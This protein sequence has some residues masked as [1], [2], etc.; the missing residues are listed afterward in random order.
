MK[1]ALALA[2]TL[3]FSYTSWAQTQLNQ[4]SV[5]SNL[6]P[7]SGANLKLLGRGI[8]TKDKKQK[9]LIACV[10]PTTTVEPTCETLRFVYVNEQHEGF[11]AGKAFPL[12][13]GKHMRARVKDTLKQLKND[14][15]HFRQHEQLMAIPFVASAGAVFGAVKWMNSQPHMNDIALWGAMFGLGAIGLLTADIVMKAQFN[16]NPVTIKFGSQDGWNWSNHQKKVRAK[17]FSKLLAYASTQAASD[18]GVK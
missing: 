17:Y 18:M 2:F 9:L 5:L 6:E 4:A 7:I 1:S 14:F 10:D 16:Y 15:D 3:I 12:L 11:F 13:P 8:Q